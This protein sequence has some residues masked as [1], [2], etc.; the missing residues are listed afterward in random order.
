MEKTFIPMSDEELMIIGHSDNN[1][2]VVK[3]LNKTI[4][5]N[6]LECLNNN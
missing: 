2:E 3:Q 4:E 6:L 5:T 1:S